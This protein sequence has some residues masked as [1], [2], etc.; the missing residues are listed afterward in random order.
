V[1]NPHAAFLGEGR[2]VTLEPY[3]TEGRAVMSY[4]TAS[5]WGL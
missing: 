1:G 3:P 4:S 2:A 5:Q